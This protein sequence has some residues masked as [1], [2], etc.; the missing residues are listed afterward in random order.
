M[1]ESQFFKA[2]EFIQL[3]NNVFL[4]FFLANSPA[5]LC[6]VSQGR[7]LSVANN[8]KATLYLFIKYIDSYERI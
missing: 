4:V 1:Q 7:F 8:L 5:K 6:V 3:V 2:L